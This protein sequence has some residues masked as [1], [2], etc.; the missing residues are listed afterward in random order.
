MSKVFKEVFNDI[1]LDENLGFYLNDTIV[2]KVSLNK[3]ENKVKVYLVSK[4]IIHRRFI[5]Q[6]KE[7]FNEDLTKDI[8]FD[9]V[10]RFELSSQF[11]SKKIIDLYTDSL[12]YEL[13]EISPVS[14]GILRKAKWK[15]KDDKLTLFLNNVNILKSKKDEI[16]YFIKN[17][18]SERFAIVFDINISPG[19][20]QVKTEKSYA[21]RKKA[22]EKKELEKI[23]INK[24]V[25][26][27]VEKEEKKPTKRG[28]S[29]D[30]DVLYGRNVDGDLFSISDLT[31][32]VGEVVIRGDIINIDLREIKN[33]R[34]IVSID[35]TDYE[36]SITVKMFAHKDE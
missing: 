32:E 36:D 11:D 24:P 5:N 30:P 25:E 35:L 29:K 23:V 31:A 16:I 18:Y 21:E 6:L 20:E 14:Y 2:E 34:Y 22:I 27:P 4:R 10:E 9:I 17:I 7:R 33:E 19:K 8:D 1:K 3:E 13:K 15:V 12:L 26:K 28:K